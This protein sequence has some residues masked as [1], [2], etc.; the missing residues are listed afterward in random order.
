MSWP[1]SSWIWALPVLVSALMPAVFF[2]EVNLYKSMGVNLLRRLC[3][4]PGYGCT[5]SPLVTEH[6][7]RAQWRLRG[8]ET[9][10][11]PF[12]PHHTTIPQRHLLLFHI[13][14]LITGSWKRNC[15]WEMKSN[16]FMISIS[17]YLLLSLT[18]LSCF[19]FI[20]VSFWANHKTFPPAA[21]SLGQWC[22]TAL[23]SWSDYPVIHHVTL[24]S[25]AQCSEGKSLQ[26]HEAGAVWLQIIFMRCICRN[27]NV[28]VP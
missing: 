4:H 11:V 13:P 26:L 7:S 16:Y 23:E 20:F 22:L 14:P 19:T 24:T 21:P 10:P 28:L 9:P 5:P 1:F 12:K 8:T 27:Y 2:P 3:A 17:C 25:K 18:L 15:S 6:P